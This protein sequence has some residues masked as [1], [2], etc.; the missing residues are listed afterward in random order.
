[1]KEIVEVA[2]GLPVSKTFH[3]RVPE[4]MRESLQIGMRVLV[5]FKGRKVTGF[6]IDCLD[7]LPKTLLDE[8]LKEVDD[9]LDEVPLLDPK[10]L[11]FYRWISEYYLYPLG[12][13]IKTGLPP[14]L[15]LKSETFLN[16]TQEGIRR[17]A[18]G[19][20]DPE[21]VRVFTEIERC[22]VVPLKKILKAF[23]G[24]LSR[25]HL[26]SWKRQGLLETQAN[27]RGK[28]VKPKLDRIIQWRGGE[29]LKPL[30]KKREGILRLIEEKREIS[31]SE[32]GK[33]FKSP[34]Q[35]LQAF[36]KMG[37]ISIVTREL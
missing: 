26:F 3:Y 1:M 19:E 20:V 32:L 18:G 24:E 12:E 4:P 7:H 35:A 22:G 5:P 10:I 6:T 30:T 16:L 33:T 9:L 28:E 8:K 17:L 21:Q 15:H 29:L 36:Q 23:P 37:L 27:L 2:V 25:A 31:Y 13:V 34:A 14:G 11:R